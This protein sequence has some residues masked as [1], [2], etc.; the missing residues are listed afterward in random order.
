MFLRESPGWY[1]NIPELRKSDWNRIC[2]KEWSINLLMSIAFVGA[3]FGS[4]LFGVA[5]DKYGRQSTY[6]FGVIATGILSFCVGVFQGN[7]YWFAVCIFFCG[8]SMQGTYQVCFVLLLE[9]VGP[10]RRTLMSTL[11]SICGTFGYMLT[12][13]VV[14]LVP[15]HRVLYFGVSLVFFGM[16][17]A[18]YPYVSESPRWLLFSK[19]HSKLKTLV[20]KMA[21]INGSKYPYL[22]LSALLTNESSSD[23]PSAK[24]VN[25][26]SLFIKPHIRSRIWIC[27]FVWFVICSSYYGLSYSAKFLGGSIHLNVFLG[28]V[29][30]LPSFFAAYLLL[31]F[32]G[33]KFSLGVMTL[34][35]S[36]SSFCSVLSS[37]F[38]L[39]TL[40]IIFALI[41]KCSVSGTFL[42][43]YIYTLELMPTSVRTLGLGIC[44]IFARVGGITVPLVLAALPDRTYVFLYFSASTFLGA[45]FL[46]FLPETRG[47]PM[48]DSIEQLISQ[49]SNSNADTMIT[50]NTEK[51][52]NQAFDSLDRHICVESK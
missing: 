42:I 28:G 43:L 15:N 51:S 10:D 21:K 11:V 16:V 25:S 52:Q 30:E 34:V 29:V 38:S 48:P 33:R 13:G 1:C 50:P 45:L 36:I 35:I 6:F 49:S 24:S 41:A 14:Y 44:S 12:P 2:D 47:L 26:V 19:Q 8:L 17:L 23:E 40:L 37:F 39:E 46:Q 22:A 32:R 5:A 3:M 27:S 4:Y 31:E 9:F 18:T 20:D 7:Y